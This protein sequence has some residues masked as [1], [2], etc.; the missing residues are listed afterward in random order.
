MEPLG[1]QMYLNVTGFAASYLIKELY[2][3]L[4]RVT[5]VSSVVHCQLVKRLLATSLYET[6]I[7]YY[8]CVKTDELSRAFEMLHVIT[9]F[10][11]LVH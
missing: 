10:Y 2:A 1:R 6:I 7:V 4:T 9:K 5:T 11:C 3:T 8:S